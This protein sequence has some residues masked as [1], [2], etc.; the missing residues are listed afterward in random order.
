MKADRTPS[1]EGR[2]DRV[3]RV[4]VH[5][6]GKLEYKNDDPAYVYRMVSDKPG[7]IEMFLKAGYE[8][9]DANGDRI[10]DKG[11]AEFSQ[12]DT[13]ESVH[14]GG[15]LRMYRMR[16]RREF[17][18]ADQEAKVRAIKQTEEQM[19]VKNPNP[20]LGQYGGLTDE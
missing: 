11:A 4:P 6:G 2:D 18:D 16:I 14:G 17:Y 8:F 9:T 19:R 5:A 12:M 3:E 20:R 7:R 15:G 1:E 10:A 13:R